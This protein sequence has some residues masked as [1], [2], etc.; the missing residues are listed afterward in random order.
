MILVQHG[1]GGE[2]HR[3]E[4]RGS[5]KQGRWGTGGK[6]ERR[7]RPRPS[8]TQLSTRRR[9]PS[10][11]PRP[12]ARRPV[13]R[14][15][16]GA[17]SARLA[18]CARL[19]QWGGARGKNELRRGGEGCGGGVMDGWCVSMGRRGS[20]DEAERPSQG[21][22]ASGPPSCPRGHPLLTALVEPLSLSNEMGGGEQQ[23]TVRGGERSPTVDPQREP[24]NRNRESSMPVSVRRCRFSARFLP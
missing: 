22:L 6:K 12:S 2:R 13:P 14:R 15:W 9:P 7:E 1:S 11:P 20:Q 10:V 23:A 19:Q 21:L 16:R 4:Q 5:E 24:Q 3:G 8:V 17:P 18:A